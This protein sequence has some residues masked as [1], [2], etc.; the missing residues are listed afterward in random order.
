MLH[1]QHV[2]RNQF[3]NAILGINTLG[4][5]VVSVGIAG[6]IILKDL[7]EC[8]QTSSLAGFTIETLVIV[9]V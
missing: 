9:V 7:A 3:S 4:L 1:A 5:I 8:F 6:F 2:S